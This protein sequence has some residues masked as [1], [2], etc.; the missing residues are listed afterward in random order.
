LFIVEQLDLVVGQQTCLIAAKGLNSLDKVK[1]VARA[2]RQ[3]HGPSYLP[4]YK[5]ALDK[6]NETIYVF[7]IDEED[8]NLMV[9]HSFD[10]GREKC[11]S[12]MFLASMFDLKKMTSTPIL[13]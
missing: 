7:V 11:L 6:M 5:F 12:T 9:G 13:L 1:L 10:V 8:A 2:V 4:I 3:N